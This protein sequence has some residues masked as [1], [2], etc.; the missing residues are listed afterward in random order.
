MLIKNCFS[1]ITCKKIVAFGTAVSICTTMLVNLGTGIIPSFRAK[2]EGNLESLILKMERSLS[3]KGEREYTM[4]LD[5]SA[6][7]AKKQMPKSVKQSDDGYFTAPYTGDYL[8]ELWGG[9]GGDGSD[10]KLNLGIFNKTY[11]GGDGGAGG[12]VSG[13]IHLERGQTLL[14][15]IGTNGTRTQSTVEGGGINGDGGNHG[16]TGSYAVG[17]GGGYSAV[18][19]Y[20]VGEFDGTIRPSEVDRMTKY[21]MIAGGG[22]GGGAGDVGAEKKSNGGDAGNMQTSPSGSLSEIDV[23]VAGTYFAGSDGLSSGKNTRHVGNGGSFVPGEIK[24]TNIGLFSS[25]SIPNDWFRTANAEAIG[26]AG[27]AGNLRG[28]SGGAGYCGGSGGI[29][30]GLVDADNVG[31][32]GGGSSFVANIVDMKSAKAENNYL[33]ANPSN[34]GG[35]CYIKF[36]DSPADYS[37]Y[38]NVT[39]DIP[40]SEYFDITNV[41]VNNMLHDLDTREE[42]SQNT[43]WSR[44]DD[45]T[46]GAVSLTGINIRPD[47]SGV[48]LNEAT[49]TVTF[50]AKDEFAG[51]NFVPLL[52]SDNITMT[53]KNGIVTPFEAQEKLSY[54]NVPLNYDIETKSFWVSADD[55]TASS[56]LYDDGFNAGLIKAPF[57]SQS[58]YRVNDSTE[59]SM[60]SPD[61]TTDYSVSYD[62]AI[63]NDMVAEIGP[64]QQ[65]Q[66]VNGTATLNVF[67]DD[68]T[69]ITPDGAT[70]PGDNWTPETADITLHVKRTLDYTD[71]YDTKIVVWAETKRLPYRD[72]VSPATDTYSTQGDDTYIV[73]TTGWYFLEARGGDG[74]KAANLRGTVSGRYDGATGGTGG[75]VSGYVFLQAGDNLNITVGNNGNSPGEMV[76]GQNG[77]D[78]TKVP[79]VPGGGGTH[80][81]IQLNNSSYLLIAGGGGGGGA[82]YYYRAGAGGS[83][84][85]GASVSSTVTPPE[86]VPNQIDGSVGGNATIGSSNNNSSSGSGGTAGSNYSA[87]DN[88]FDFVNNPEYTEPTNSSLTVPTVRITR[89]A[90]SSNIPYNVQS[91]TVRTSLTNMQLTLNGEISPYFNLAEGSE[92]LT[93]GYSFYLPDIEVYTDEP[94]HIVY[95]RSG[96][97]EIHIKETPIEGFLGGNN[98]P[99]FSL[100]PTLVFNDNNQTHTD[101][102]IIMKSNDSLNLA[103]VKIPEISFSTS[104]KTV[105]Y[106]TEVTV[107][108]IFVDNGTFNISDYSEI[109]KAY[110][111]FSSDPETDTFNATETQSYTISYNLSPKTAPENATAKVIPAISS[112]THEQ[113]STL[114]VNC[115]VTKNLTNLI[116]D[117]ETMIPCGKEYTCKITPET[118]YL[119][120]QTIEVM[121]N[122]TVL[123]AGSGNYYYDSLSGDIKIPADNV[124][125]N[126]T[127]TAQARVKTY[128]LIF[129]YATDKENSV[130]VTKT[131][132]YPAGTA[133]P[134]TAPLEDWQTWAN[135]IEA[136]L[137]DDF[138]GYSFEWDY[139]LDDNQD[140]LTEMPARTHYVFGAFSKI[141]RILT[142]NYDMPVGSSTPP[143]ATYQQIYYDGDVANIPTPAMEGYIPDK[144]SVNVTFD[145][146]NITETITYK[147]LENEIEI[148]YVMEDGSVA[149]PTYTGIASVETGSQTINSPI[150]TGYTPDLASVVVPAN[151]MYAVV[152]YHPNVIAVQLD[153]GEG[154]SL[155]ASDKSRVA[156]YGMD[157]GVSSCDQSDSANYRYTHNAL[158]IPIKTGYTFDGWYNTA[159]EEITENTI[160]EETSAVTLTAKWTANIVKLTVNYQKNNEDEPF[161][162]ETV[163]FLPEDNPRSYT[164]NEN[165]TP[166]HYSLVDSTPATI[167]VGNVNKTVYVLFKGDECTLTIHYVMSDGTTAPDDYTFA[168]SYE[169]GSEYSEVVPIPASIDEEI[170]TPSQRVISGIMDDTEKIVTI[171]FIRAG[172]VMKVTVQWD[173]LTYVA[174]DIVWNPDRH[175]YMADASTMTRT[176]GTGNA[177]ITVIN[178]SSVP[179]TATFSYE[180]N[181]SFKG[182][183]CEFRKDGNAVNSVVVPEGNITPQ[184]DS[185]EVTLFGTFPV[186]EEGT[187]RAGTCNVAITAG[188]N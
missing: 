26:G 167:Q 71:S 140:A 117:G 136:D 90:R 99:L 20:D 134:A 163:E 83:G 73:P 183:G 52:T 7:L 115:M 150:I 125:G 22:G 39:I 111:D 175:T 109:Q 155:G 25:S 54:V 112:Q 187:Y 29:M 62:I 164:I 153:A 142:I 21:I 80:S 130:Y 179:I 9:K 44:T 104:D 154:G 156:Y 133:F 127:I 108:D 66:T 132:S 40:K 162:T 123:T 157:Y 106:Y 87:I 129:Q 17:G 173:C 126:I 67:A 184:D 33:E 119:L 77:V 47:M 89:I 15:N 174:N 37:H 70:P 36:L 6:Y 152:T 35:C 53:D 49:I 120:P 124:A 148:H 86:A 85:P 144:S 96:E 81:A 74:G 8:I 69:Y 11:E 51:G 131:Y 158:P 102:N 42:T 147:A 103:N 145:G 28:G 58:A 45:A 43:A 168:D 97:K 122:D 146:N 159:D 138:I 19:L 2:G 65:P 72:A 34:V 59:T 170:Y 188:G 137:N 48:E 50:K 18:Y 88:T 55:N 100:N 16:K 82:S 105:D 94:N 114:Y 41:E 32:G 169:Y 24:E 91:E 14:Y 12:H 181:M 118:G 177:N 185:V 64:K 93:G 23:T 78:L 3:Y 141:P 30:D 56:A 182:M 84:K 186:P 79:G 143:P 5:A 95:A 13:V 113:N 165:K 92:N 178:E 139:Q 98:V 76:Y 31:G 121:V 180:K 110:V 166:E 60:L 171:T 63:L 116:S 161:F 68:V 27:G 38:D 61:E 4:T 75:F 160:C 172:E 128:D 10:R 101:P 176:N 57:T 135:S 46:T 151:G 1:R 107:P 149:A